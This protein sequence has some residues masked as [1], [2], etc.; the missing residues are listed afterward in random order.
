MFAL[1]VMNK[2][3]L[4]REIG[5]RPL[6]NFQNYCSQTSNL[7]LICQHLAITC[8]ALKDVCH[9]CVCQSTA[10]PI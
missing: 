4:M 1:L 8:L 9:K 6:F 7:N 10:H 5:G 3:I 2:L